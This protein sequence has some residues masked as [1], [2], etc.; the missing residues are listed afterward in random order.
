GGGTVRSPKGFRCL[1]GK[2]EPH[3]CGAAAGGSTFS[4]CKGVNWPEGETE[5]MERRRDRETRLREAAA[6]AVFN[7]RSHAPRGNALSF[8]ALRRG[9]AA[10]KVHRRR[11]YPELAFPRRAW[12]R[13]SDRS[14]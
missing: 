7:S 9:R 1:V 2:Q 11:A 5:R 12:E 6:F 13:G 4:N 3:H 8:D 10:G 14:I